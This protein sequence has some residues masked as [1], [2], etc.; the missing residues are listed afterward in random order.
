MRSR[1]YDAGG[2]HYPRRFLICRLGHFGF[3]L[4]PL[5]DTCADPTLQNPPG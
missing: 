2:I 5:S 1:T 4:E 3:N